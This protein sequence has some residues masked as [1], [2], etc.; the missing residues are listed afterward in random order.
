MQTSTNCWIERARLETAQPNPAPPPQ[1]ELTGLLEETRVRGGDWGA[2]G[3]PD[4]RGNLG[5]P[6]QVA[7][8]CACRGLAVPRTLRER[9]GPALVADSPGPLCRR[10]LSRLPLPSPAVSIFGYFRFTFPE[11]SYLAVAGGAAGGER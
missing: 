10:R 9:W 6:D 11:H 7:S 4:S 3:H 8:P 5:F 2:Q 1:A